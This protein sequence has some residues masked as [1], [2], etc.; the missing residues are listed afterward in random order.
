MNKNVIHYC[1]KCIVVLVIKIA[2]RGTRNVVYR[3][4]VAAQIGARCKGMASYRP[5]SA[6]PRYLQDRRRGIW[7]RQQTETASPPAVFSVGESI[8][9]I[10]HISEK[11]TKF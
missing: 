8:K 6:C 9:K 11:K 7:I 2:L 1:N 3:K 10:K 5:R 4:G